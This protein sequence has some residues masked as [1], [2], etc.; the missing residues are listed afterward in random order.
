MA[1]KLQETASLANLKRILDKSIPDSQF[2]EEEL[3]KRKV[4]GDTKF[5]NLNIPQQVGD[6]YQYDPAYLTSSD[7]EIMK[8]NDKYKISNVDPFAPIIKSTTTQGALV[9]YS[10]GLLSAPRPNTSV[11]GSGASYERK[12]LGLPSDINSVNARIAKRG[13]SQTTFTDEQIAAMINVNYNDPQ[14]PI[15]NDRGAYSEQYNQARDQ[16][17][18]EIDM[19]ENKNIATREKYMVSSGKIESLNSDIKDL[20]AI[21][22]AQN[23]Q[24]DL[25][26]KNKEETKR[27]KAAAR[28]AVQGIKR[29]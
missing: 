6:Y 17:L 27:L 1:F 10:S 5:E 12:N 7:R 4:W 11:Y 29:K 24:V 22:E 28:A 8:Y 20:N 16:M 13:A 26:T 18:R 9:G 3:A 21:V 15:Y 25:Y 23:K 19:L 2:T 14:N